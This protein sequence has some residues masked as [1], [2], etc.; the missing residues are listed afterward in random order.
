MIARVVSNIIA[1]LDTAIEILLT[2]DPLLT[3]HDSNKIG[4]WN[5]SDDLS[6]HRF[7]KKNLID[8]RVIRSLSVPRKV[9]LV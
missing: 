7:Q 4:N 8:R 5:I 6:S 1:P 2:R 3:N 9:E